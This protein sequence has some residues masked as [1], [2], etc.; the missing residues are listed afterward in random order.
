MF[1]QPIYFR[2][3]LSAIL[4][5]SAK[6]MAAPLFKPLL[7]EMAWLE[8]AFAERDVRLSLRNGH[9]IRPA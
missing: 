8:K 2:P 5:A 9:M 3:A 1:G 4:P 7:P 6:S